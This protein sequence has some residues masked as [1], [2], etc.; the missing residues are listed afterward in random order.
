M[1]G[2]LAA[3][4]YLEQTT[5]YAKD[6]LHPA[7]VTVQAFKPSSGSQDEFGVK[8]SLLDGKITGSVSYFKIAQQNYS[9]PNSEYYTLIAQGNAAAANL[10]QNPLYLNLESKGWEFEG[11][12]SFN[13]NLTL[14]GNYTSYKERQPITN[15]RVRGVPD[16]AGALYLDYEFTDGTLKGFGVNV[17]V[18]YKSDV[19]GENVTGYTT[20]APIQGVG[21]VAK[22][23]SFLVAGR[24]LTN[25]G[26]SYRTA[27]W[28]VRLMIANVTD[29]DYILAAGSRTSAIVGQPRSWLF[30]TTYNF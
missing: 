14:L 20:T 11:T 7:A 30:S 17:G 25:V 8:T 27:G 22:Q 28:T 15:V 19:A 4:T 21:F 24:T 2:E 16:Q 3:G 9:V 29:K 23:P 1:P 26:F 18:D 6:A 10:L 12:Y 13:K 5:T